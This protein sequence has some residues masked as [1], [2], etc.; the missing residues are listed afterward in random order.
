M[1]TL[2]HND[3][4]NSEKWLTVIADTERLILESEDATRVKRLRWALETFRYAL[5]EEMPYPDI[6]TQ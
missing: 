6:S 5:R 3:V 4:E 1:S 2:N